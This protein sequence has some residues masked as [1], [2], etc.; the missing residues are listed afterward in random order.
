MGGRLSR[1]DRDDT[2]SLSSKS[3]KS[4]DQKRHNALNDALYP[5]EDEE[6]IWKHLDKIPQDVEN[7]IHGYIKCQSPID[8]ETVVRIKLNFYFW[9]RNL[10]RYVLDNYGAEE[11]YTGDFLKETFQDDILCDLVYL[12]SNDFLFDNG[13]IPRKTLGN[14]TMNLIHSRNILDK[15]AKPKRL[16]KFVVE[17]KDETISYLINLKKTLDGKHASIKKMEQNIQQMVNAKIT[18]HHS[19]VLN[20]PQ[21][22]LE[23][24]QIQ[25]LLETEGDIAAL[26]EL[27]VCFVYYSRKNTSR[28]K[29]NDM[30]QLR[31]P[32]SSSSSSNSIYRGE[33]LEVYFPQDSWLKNNCE[34]DLRGTD[35]GLGDKIINYFLTGVHQE[36]YLHGAPVFWMLYP[37]IRESEIRDDI[38][39]EIPSAFRALQ[40]RI[41]RICNVLPLQKL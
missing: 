30:P 32:S 26:N 28:I 5:L 25:E 11:G 22:L 20:I 3:I 21:N 12:G 19:R 34:P 17:K 8:K 2:F 6:R 14:W 4:K 39:P 10:L 40:T 16:K 13:S 1:D 24:R 37:K 35:E 9:S 31:A 33:G 29:D 36:N 41:S 7:F 23:L 18:V 15:L 38:I 27:R